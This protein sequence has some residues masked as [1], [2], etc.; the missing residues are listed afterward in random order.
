[1]QPTFGH[2][3]YMY[4]GCRFPTKIISSYPTEDNN[5]SIRKAI[6]LETATQSLYAMDYSHGLWPH[7]L[8]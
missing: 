1:M 2:I 3:F 8:G 5:H 6:K 4:F 7:S